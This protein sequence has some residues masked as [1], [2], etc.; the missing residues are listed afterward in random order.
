MLESRVANDA[1]W[2]YIDRLFEITPT[3]NGLAASQL[4]EIA[5]YV[6]LDVSKFQECLDSGKYANKI[7]QQIQQAQAAGGRGTPHSIIISGD[8]KI[9][10]QGAQPIESVKALIDSLL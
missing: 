8:Q 4:P 3:N 9:P 5:D 2:A 1:F 7:Q 10:I 6:G